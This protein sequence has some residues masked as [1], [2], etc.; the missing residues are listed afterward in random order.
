MGRNISL[1]AGGR[2]VEV[3][4]NRLEV[5]W[6]RLKEEKLESNEL[7]WQEPWGWPFDCVIW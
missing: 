5:V 4:W 3:I 7:E 1:L 6:I 2:L